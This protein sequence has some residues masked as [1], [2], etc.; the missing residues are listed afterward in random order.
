MPKEKAWSSTIHT[1]YQKI[2][3]HREEYVMNYACGFFNVF[4]PSLHVDV[5]VS[6]ERVLFGMEFIFFRELVYD[7]L[8][9]ISF[10]NIF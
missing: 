3:N 4:L 6:E 7:T 2:L 5:F 10:A 9:K 1:A 8:A